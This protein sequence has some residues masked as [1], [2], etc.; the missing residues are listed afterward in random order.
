MTKCLQ[1]NKPKQGQN[2]VS[3]H[4]TSQN[5]VKGR[6]CFCNSC[7]LPL[8]LKFVQNH[9]C[10][11]FFFF[12]SSTLAS[13]FTFKN[14]ATKI[15]IHYFESNYEIVFEDTLIN[16]R[17]YDFVTGA[18]RHATPRFTLFHHTYH[19]VLPSGGFLFWLFQTT[20][21]LD[22]LGTLDTSVMTR[23]RLSTRS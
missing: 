15:L 10:V 21:N 17:T 19:E 14:I 16:Q 4:T 11:V 7:M 22:R 2:Q 18:S 8:I 12:F 5:K 3:L 9:S 20:N 1:K 13:H 6:Q 23:K